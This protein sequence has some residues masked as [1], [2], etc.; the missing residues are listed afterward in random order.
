M[1][2]PAIL[3]ADGNYSVA[4]D[5]R[6]VVA[7]YHDEFRRIPAV[8][9]ASVFIHAAPAATVARLPTAVEDNAR[10]ARFGYFVV[11]NPD[12]SEHSVI[13]TV[14][15]GR[16][17]INSARRIMVTLIGADF[18]HV[19]DILRVTL[20]FC[21]RLHAEI[22]FPIPTHFVYVTVFH[23]DVFGNA[24]FRRF[25]ANALRAFR[26]FN[27]EVENS[28]VV[29]EKTDSRTR[30]RAYYRA[31]VAVTADVKRLFLGRTKIPE[32]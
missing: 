30:I 1:L 12:V 24:V 20:A 6:N 5:V 17:E 7:A 9:H 22:V 8:V 28:R 15:F 23:D 18:F 2:Y 26:I 14:A 27:F 3:N 16:D 32:R 10:S 4:A 21:E 13:L 29:A 11:H 19:H 25:N 31:P